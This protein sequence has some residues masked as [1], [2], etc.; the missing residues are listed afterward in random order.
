VNAVVVQ[1]ANGDAFF[2]GIGMTVVAFALRLWVNKRFWVVLLTAMWLLGIS[3]V[4][5][6]AAPISFWLYGIWF[7]LCIAARIVFNRRISSRLK[8]LVTIAFAVFSLV[9]CLV[10]LPFH[11]AKTISVSKGQ[12]DLC[13]RRFHR[14][15]DWRKRTNVASRA[16]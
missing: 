6:S 1:L 16:G 9:V 10:E 3:F 14:C 5:L 13:Y 11:L 4:V 15:G 2:I 12:D 7:S 8:N